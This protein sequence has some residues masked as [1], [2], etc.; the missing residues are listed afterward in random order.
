M[1]AMTAI[2]LIGLTY[3]L[4]SLPNKTENFNTANPGARTLDGAAYLEK[5]NAD[6][7]AAIQW[8]A[9][10]QPGI[11]AEAVGGSYSEYARVSTYSGQPSVLGWPGHESQWRGGSAE[12]GG[13]ADDLTMLYATSNWMEAESILKRYDIRYVYLGRL[14][15]ATYDVDERKFA[16]NLSEVYRQ[17]QVVIY[18]V[19]P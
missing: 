6:D 3:P 9:Q 14:E 16:S 7:Y 8:L 11:V 15:H 12:M 10:A 2:L 1:V 17:G 19:A 5:Y 13:R 4:L 18:E